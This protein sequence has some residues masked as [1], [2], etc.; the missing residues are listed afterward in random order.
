MN[1]FTEKTLDC[2]YWSAIASVDRKIPFRYFKHSFFIS[3]VPL[4]LFL[5]VFNFIIGVGIL[6]TRIK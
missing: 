3:F 2:S 4:S 5:S 6:Y 1:L